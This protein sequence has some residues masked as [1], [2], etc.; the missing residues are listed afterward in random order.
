MLRKLQGI[1]KDR[2]EQGG[3]SQSFKTYFAASVA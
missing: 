1:K 2:P 3:P